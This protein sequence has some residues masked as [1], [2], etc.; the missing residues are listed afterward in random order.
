MNWTFKN[1]GGPWIVGGW[2]MCSTFRAWCKSFG[3]KFI[4]RFG[5]F[6][7]SLCNQVSQIWIHK[8]NKNF[9]VFWHKISPAM[10]SHRCPKMRPI[11]PL[12]MWTNCSSAPKVMCPQ[13]NW[14]WICRGQCKNMRPFS[15]PDQ[16]F[17]FLSYFNL[18]R[19]E[20]PRPIAPNKNPFT[21]TLGRGKSISN[22]CF[23]N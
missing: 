3:R 5:H 19:F 10:H 20:P 16:F 7:A 11:N 9:K 12:K 14:G 6:W 22:Y 15:A 18:V 1:S 17:R 21:V 8:N 2:R 4:A 23:F 13:P